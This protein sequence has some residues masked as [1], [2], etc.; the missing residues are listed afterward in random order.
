MNKLHKFSMAI[1]AVVMIAGFS[2]FKMSERTLKTDDP[3]VEIW[4]F[5]GDD[6]NQVKN[7]LF[8]SKTTE[9]CGGSTAVVCEIHAP[10]GNPNRPDLSSPVTQDLIDQAMSSS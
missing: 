4:Y 8:Y 7:P 9:S 6:E 2:A 5:N 3:E 10:E 1:V